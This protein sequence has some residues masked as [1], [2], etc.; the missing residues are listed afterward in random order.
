MGRVES[1]QRFPFVSLEKA[2]ERA[3]QLYEADHRG[4]EISVGVAFAAWQYSEKSSGGFQ[5]T[6]AL[7]M[8]GLVEDIGAKDSRKLKLTKSALNYF[9]DEREDVRANLLQEFAVSPPL[10]ATLWRQWG[11]T[12]PS[13]MIARSHLKVDRNLSEQNARAVLGIYK[14]NL[15]FA[16]LKGDGKSKEVVSPPAD[17]QNKV[18]VGDFIQWTSGGQ[19][20]FKP[21]RKV[22]W[23]S[24][25]GSHLRVF[26]SPTG[27]PVSEIK[28]VGD[29]SEA[30]MRET[31]L[32]HSGNAVPGG[33]SA[34]SGQQ[35][36]TVYQ[37][38][39]RLQITADVDA[40]G[41]KK[42][43]ELLNKYEEI[44]KIM[45]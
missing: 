42:L 21:A 44:L 10:L 28:V 5:T 20:Q 27:I 39:K 22:E 6:A 24:E 11:A 32:H 36:F 26:G 30:S 40:E 1:D 45:N 17:T 25:D 18:K 41:L 29:H 14:D 34:A 2:I 43:K 8:Y 23:I 37:T 31:P 33:P 4:G 13:D 3:R 12:P 15:V 35:D 16:N 19:D 9:R 7:K 38:G